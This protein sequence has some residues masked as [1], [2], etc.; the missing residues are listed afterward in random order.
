[1]Q[2]TFGPWPITIHMYVAPQQNRMFA[3]DGQWGEGGL[4]KRLDEEMYLY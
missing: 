4:H 2:S 1:M 3:D